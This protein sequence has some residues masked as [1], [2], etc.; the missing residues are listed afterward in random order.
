MNGYDFDKTIYNGDSSIEFYIFLIKKKPYLIYKLL[1]FSIYYFLYLI[2]VIDKIAI[3]EKMFSIVSK[4]KNIDDEI[5][6]FW[7]NKKLC[8]WYLNQKKEN[9]VIISASPSFLL[10]PFCLKNGITNLI[11]SDVDKNTGKFIG[12]NCYG[13]E[14]LVQYKKIFGKKIINTFYSDS[15]SDKCMLTVSNKFYIVHNKNKTVNFEI[16][17]KD[18]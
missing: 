15:L 10:K 11:A 4:F 1:I 3:K 13:N 5:N 6:L 12:K 18:N 9:D 7:N 14:K 17:K 16:I 8:G 2:K